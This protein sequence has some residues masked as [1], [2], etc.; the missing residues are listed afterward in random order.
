MKTI[1]ISDEIYDK[2]IKLANEMTT[3]DPRATR[4]PHMFQIRD[5]KKVYRDYPNGDIQIYLDRQSGSEIETVD[6]LVD[7]L[8]NCEIEFEETEIREMWE[9]DRDFGLQDWIEENATELEQYSY[10]LEPEYTNSFLTAKA[11]QEHLDINYYHYHAKADVYL[12]HAWRNP[13][14]DLVSGFLCSLVGKN[15]HT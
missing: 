14:A 12:N 11:A 5:W 2:L 7:Y 1:E 8:N 6:E 9:N 15:I 4:M 3:Q 10:S 13:E